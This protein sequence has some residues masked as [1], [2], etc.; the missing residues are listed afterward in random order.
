MKF[1]CTSIVY[2]VI[3][4]LAD[5]QS[6]DLCEVYKQ[7]RQ[8]QNLDTIEHLLN[9]G[10]IS[11]T[12]QAELL[13]MRG[14]LKIKYNKNS[15]G[16]RPSL[17]NP[18]LKSAYSD[19][20][21]AIEQVTEERKVEFVFRRYTTLSDV[22]LSYPEDRSD[23]NL[24]SSHGYKKDR[25]GM[26]AS[27]SVRYDG[28][29]WLGFD[30]ALF[31]GYTSPYTLKDGHGS[32]IAKRKY[33][34]S[35]SAFVLGYSHNLESS[36]SDFNFSLIR[37]EAPLFI[38]ILNVGYIRTMGNNSWYYR[39]QLGLGYYWFQLSA[40]YNIFFRNNSE[41]GQSKWMVQLRTKINL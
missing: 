2:F 19:F 22:D 3:L 39:P 15:L 38:D 4:C 32:T 34:L 36:A 31:S 6:L 18:I 16:K 14:L 29:F 10:E 26:A 25:F 27:L 1:I 30:F 23:L 8:H 20:T 13:T 28:S 5:G 40:G 12:D 7:A 35:A 21:T 24:L 41:L 17:K 9:S 11:S 33:T 37:I